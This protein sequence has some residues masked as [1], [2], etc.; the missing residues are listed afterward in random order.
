MH[1]NFDEIIDRKGTNSV[2]FEGW[3]GY[4]FDTNGDKPFP[5]K[6]E[7]YIRMWVADMDF[8]TPPE[9]LDAIRARLDRQILGYTLIFDP[10]YF[11]TLKQWFLKRYQWTINT[12]HIVTAPGVVPALNRLVNLLTGAGDSILINTPS[13][14]P[15]KTAG[16]IN[17]RTVYYSSLMWVNNAYE[18]NFEDIRQQL[19]DPEKNIK[20]FIFCNPHNPTGRVW[21]ETELRKIGEICQERNIWLISDE[22]HCDLLRK[23]IRHTPLAKLFPENERIITCTAPS[24]TFN[25]AGNLM[26]HIFIPDEQV[27]KQWLVLYFDLLSPLSVAAVQAAYAHCEDWLEQLKA[28]LDGNFAYLSE[29]LN[30]YLPECNFNIPDATYLAWI[31]FSAYIPHIPYSNISEFF[32]TE[33]GVLLEGGNMFVDNGDG[34]IRL[35]LACP[36]S[37]LEE[38]LKRII[39]AIQQHIS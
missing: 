29:Q 36:R 10:A 31:D 30:T 39:H 18:L 20:V 14:T 28:Y 15:F 2:S 21:T 37:L 12:D 38:G 35:N 4:M 3:K 32:A 11:D 23:G 5:F 9:I 24:K 26:S 8:A 7:E 17:N 16:D 13:Y 34:Y 27:R 33:A 25:L 1:Y 22:I 19:D 6:E